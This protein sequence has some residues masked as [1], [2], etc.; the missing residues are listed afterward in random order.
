MAGLSDGCHYTTWD[1]PRHPG[2][3]QRLVSLESGGSVSIQTTSVVE[4]SE[5]TLPGAGCLTPF[6]ISHLLLE[7]IEQAVAQNLAVV[8]AS[9]SSPGAKGS[10]GN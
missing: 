6:P 9:S 4:A 1:L 10:L 3:Q 5:N 8:S 7:G 2:A